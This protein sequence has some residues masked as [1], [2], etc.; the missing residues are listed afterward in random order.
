MNFD[1]AMLYWQNI[2]ENIPEIQLYT[3][4]YNNVV[5]GGMQGSI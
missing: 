1:E 4:A 3:E 2:K 5:A